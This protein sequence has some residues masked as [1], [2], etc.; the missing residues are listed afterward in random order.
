[1]QTPLFQLFERSR[2]NGERNDELVSYLTNLPHPY[3]CC[4]S[5][6]A[7]SRSNST[8]LMDQKDLR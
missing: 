7:A 8:D 1:M 3:A 5:M 6:I 2:G 4:V